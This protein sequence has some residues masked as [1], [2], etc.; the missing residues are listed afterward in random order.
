MF[1]VGPLE[2][3]ILLV[4]VL[5]IV[6][7]KKAPDVARSLGKSVRELKDTVDGAQRDMRSAVLGDDDDDRRA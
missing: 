4:V 2:I 5:L 6:G 7:P 1:G 3:V